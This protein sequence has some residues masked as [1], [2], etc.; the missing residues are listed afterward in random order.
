MLLI[1]GYIFKDIALLVSF[2]SLSLQLEPDLYVCRA[3]QH[4][5][6]SRGEK[7]EGCQLQHGRSHRTMSLHR[8][9]KRTVKAFT[10]E[11][12]NNVLKTR[13]VVDY[14]DLA[15]IDLSKA[16]TPDGRAELAREARDAMTSKGFF[17]VVGHGYTE[18][19]VSIFS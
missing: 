18:E 17:Y 10:F 19:E 12:R 1:A 6:K 14:A 2:R 5:D 8:R 4:P 13:R 16:R 15:I 9:R 11:R 7:H 3:D